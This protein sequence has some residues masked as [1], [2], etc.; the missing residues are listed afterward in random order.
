L[1]VLFRN[2]LT[3]RV[4]A[5]IECKWKQ[6]VRHGVQNRQKVGWG[7]NENMFLMFSSFD[8]AS[9]LRPGGS[10]SG[11]PNIFIKNG[12]Q[13]PCFTLEILRGV[14]LKCQARH[15]TLIRIRRTDH[16]HS[17]HWSPIILNPYEFIL[18]DVSHLCLL[19]GR[20]LHFK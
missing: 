2:E 3:L 8:T 17:S 14:L 10:Q 19:H 18:T 9:L 16:D 13:C 7:L 12:I 6:S 5:H 4:C 15:I 20:V 1:I 11:R